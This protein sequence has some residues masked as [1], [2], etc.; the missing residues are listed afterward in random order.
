MIVATRIEALEHR[1]E[2][3]SARD[4]RLDHETPL[5]AGLNGIFPS[6][7]LACGLS[8]ATW[9][10]P[11]RTTTLPAVLGWKPEKYV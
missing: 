10:W 11:Q 3:A 5:H 2:I 9:G 4:L 8:R 7:F 1:I 6:S